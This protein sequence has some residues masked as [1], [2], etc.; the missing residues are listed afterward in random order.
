[1][2]AAVASARSSQSV[3]VRPKR[4]VRYRSA[5][6][7]ADQCWVGD[8]DLVGAELSGD[9]GDCYVGRAR[10]SVE[11]D[12]V[13]ADLLGLLD[14]RQVFP[15]QWVANTVRRAGSLRAR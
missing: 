7:V 1:M 11:H 2:S 5:S 13:V 14:R 9:E 8:H 6:G 4:P 3:Q 15:V 10:R 12:E